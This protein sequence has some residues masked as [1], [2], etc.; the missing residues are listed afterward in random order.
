[1]SMIKTRIDQCKKGIVSDEIK[2][3]AH[4]ESIDPALLCQRIAEGKI[5]VLHNNRHTISSACAVG[6]G[7]RTKVNANI[8]TS[9]DV[10]SDERELKKLTIC[11]QAKAD[12]VMDLSTGPHLKRTRQLI[13]KHAHI[14]V[15]TVPIYQTVVAALEQ[16][17]P[18]N[19]ITVDDFFKTIEEH[20]EEG[21]DFLTIHC[22][23]TRALVETF[24]EKKRLMGVVSRGGAFMIEWIYKTG[25][26]NP[27][28]E[29]YDR[30]LDICSQNDV[31]ISLGDGMRPGCIHDATDYYQVRELEVL[32]GLARQSR[33]KNV[34]VIIEGPGHIPLNEV[35]KNIQMQKKICDEAPFY[36]L[37]PI[38]T[39]IAPGYD[40][41]TSAIGGA[42]AGAA[43]ADFLC[44]VTPAEHLSLPDEDDV[45]MGIIAARIA[46]HAADIAKNVPGAREKDYAMSLC[47]KKR[48]WEGQIA[49]ALDPARVV[50]VRNRGESRCDDACTMCSEYCSMKRLEEI[51]A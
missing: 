49:C 47:R 12:A 29:Y 20:S 30:L 4:H 10:H 15:G 35:E 44:Y 28:F 8:G 51:M 46:A 42:I 26:E 40:H 25:K 14:P 27:F 17:K 24:V 3:I 41:I 48:D 13:L 38:V 45:H 22:G 18:I 11:H 7:L 32:G 5:V 9:L 16:K 43:G 6:K 1:M 2:R 23:I 19:E 50:Q 34:Q 33:E 31:T 39:D 37:G 36:V 21:V